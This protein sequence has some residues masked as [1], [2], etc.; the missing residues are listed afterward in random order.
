MVANADFN[1]DGYRDIVVNTICSVVLQD[2]D[3]N[4]PLK[5]YKNNGVI[6]IKKWMLLQRFVLNGWDKK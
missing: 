2:C 6:I 5:I 3:E 1:H 4:T